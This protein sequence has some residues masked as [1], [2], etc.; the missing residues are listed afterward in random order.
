MPPKS[1]QCRGSSAQ[2]HW[3]VGGH[4]RLGC[5]P[6]GCFCR[7]DNIVRDAEAVRLELV[8]GSMSVMGQS[9]GGFCIFTYLSMF[10]EGIRGQLHI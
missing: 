6:E 8:K 10:P 2:L 9:F 1:Q 7:A 5:Q 4:T 3:I